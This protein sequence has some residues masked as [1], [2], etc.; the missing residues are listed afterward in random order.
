MNERLV[1]NEIDPY[2]AE[3]LRKLMK[4]GFIAEGEVDERSIT[5]VQP[6]D[7]QGFAQCHFFA[8]IGGWSYALRLAGWPD[9]RAVWTGSRPCQP[10]SCAGQRKGHADQRHL[11][12]AFLLTA[13]PS[14]ALQRAL[15]NRLR[16]RMDV[17]GS[18]EYELI[19]KPWDMAGGSPI[20]CA[21]GVEAPYAG[22]RIYLGANSMRT[23]RGPQ[24]KGRVDVPVW[25][26]VIWQE[27]AG[28]PGLLRETRG[29][30]SHATNGIGSASGSQCDERDLEDS[31]WKVFEWVETLDGRKFRSKP[32]PSLLAHGI[33]GRVG[34]LR[35][36]GNAIV[37]QVAKTFIEAYVEA[38]K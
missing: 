12:P 2:C 1:G 25:S 20:W 21:A 27:T 31:P 5:D 30:T 24:A 11:W 9:D 18:P 8:G 14:A 22:Q 37:L 17:N 38:T 13:S 29:S 26:H 19:W 34:R 7:L 35:G 23:E 4:L 3:W 6:N 32:G 28:G 16:A 15:E 33:P 36:Y 10:L